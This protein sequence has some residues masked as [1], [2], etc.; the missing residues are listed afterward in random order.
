MK[1]LT[2]IAIT[3]TLIALGLSHAEAHAFADHSDP[4]VGST[5]PSSPTSVKIWFTEDLEGA[6]SKIK[7]SNSKGQEVDKKDSKVDSGTKSLLSVSVPK[8][9]PGTYKVEWSVVSTDTHHTTGT[10]TFD[11]KGS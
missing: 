3:L 8:L 4:K 11:V 9:A 10:F 6:F 5:V 1:I 2:T 7:V